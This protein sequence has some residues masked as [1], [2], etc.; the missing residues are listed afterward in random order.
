MAY[1]APRRRMPPEKAA[2]W[3]ARRPGQLQQLRARRPPSRR[4][5]API[6]NITVLH[7]AAAILTIPLCAAL[8]LLAWNRREQTHNL[9]AALRR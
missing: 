5:S 8:L 3:L 4:F 6:I 1:R 9:A 2:G 7:S